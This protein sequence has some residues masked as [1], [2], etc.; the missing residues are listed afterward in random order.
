MPQPHQSSDG[1]VKRVTQPRQSSVDMIRRILRFIDQYTKS[2]GYP[3]SIRDIGEEFGYASNVAVQYQ[4]KIA[5]ENGW[6]DRTPK[7]SRSIRVTKK[8]FEYLDGVEND[9]E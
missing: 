3:P 1:M 8:G 6:L 7:R 9:K 2:Y 4:L 5:R